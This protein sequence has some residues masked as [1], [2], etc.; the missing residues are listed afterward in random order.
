MKKNKDISKVRDLGVYGLPYESL[1]ISLPTHIEHSEYF[2]EKN[3]RR[4]QYI[5]NESP[6]AKRYQFIGQCKDSLLGDHFRGKDDYIVPD[7]MDDSYNCRKLRVGEIKYPGR[8]IHRIVNTKNGPIE[9]I[10]KKDRIIREITR[11]EIKADLI[12]S[13]SFMRLMFYYIYTNRDRAAY[14]RDRIVVYNDEIFR[15]LYYIYDMQY[16]MYRVST[17]DYLCEYWELCNTA[18]MYTHMAIRDWAMFKALV[19]GT[20]PDMFVQEHE[21]ARYVSLAG[22]KDRMKKTQDCV[23]RRQADRRKAVMRDF[24]CKITT[25]GN[26]EKNEF[27]ISRFFRKAKNGNVK[28]IIEN[29]RRKVNEVILAERL[30]EDLLKDRRIYQIMDEVLEKL[31]MT[32]NELYERIVTLGSFSPRSNKADINGRKHE[33]SKKKKDKVLRDLRFF[34][35]FCLIY[36]GTY[37]AVVYCADLLS[38]NVARIPDITTCSEMEEKI[39]RDPPNIAISA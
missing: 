32:L 20:F 19:Q 26:P 22:W 12:F 36:R 10:F 2:K 35:D 15:A 9:N 33:W 38:Y 29:V 30:S 24:I 4:I 8:F 3:R 1:N 5:L 34:G 39:H 6:S 37:L 27:H 11:Q 21:K 25:K 14:F 13:E 23:K 7:R 31:G 18:K 28:Y 17:D 16:R